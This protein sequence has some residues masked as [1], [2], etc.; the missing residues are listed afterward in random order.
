MHV[1]MLIWGPMIIIGPLVDATGAPIIPGAADTDSKMKKG[2][3]KS[4]GTPIH[5]SLITII[6]NLY[7]MYSE[8]NWR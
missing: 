2:K 4:G 6:S 3:K 1:P 7:L 8:A 5:P